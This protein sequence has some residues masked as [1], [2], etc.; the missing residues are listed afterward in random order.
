MKRR[1]GDERKG[2]GEHDKKESLHGTASFGFSLKDIRI[3]LF[4]NGF[5]R[6]L[7]FDGVIR[8]FGNIFPQIGIYPAPV[9]AFLITIPS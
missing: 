1:A 7:R 8:P 6:P 9:W 2:K 4:L 5:A 3:G